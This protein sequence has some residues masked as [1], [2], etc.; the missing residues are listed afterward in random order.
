MTYFV[1]IILI[2]IEGLLSN[3][4]SYLPFS[5]PLKFFLVIL[6]LLF[7]GCAFKISKKRLYLLALIIGLIYDVAYTNVYFWHSLLFSLALFIV[8]WLER[9]NK[10]CT[11]NIIISFLIVETIDYFV[12]VFLF[13]ISFDLVL[14]FNYIL[15]ALLS[16]VIFFIL[17]YIYFAYFDKVK[18]IRK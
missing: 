4:V 2:F 10:N 1:L 9:K 6:G 16:Q 11:L 3:Y 12:A 17:I 18:R 13:S 14:Y 5:F 8:L 7:I 15:G